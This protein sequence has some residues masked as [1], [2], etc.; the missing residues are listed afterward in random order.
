MSAL[1]E[2]AA[3]RLCAAGEGL[4]GVS[5]PLT[6][7]TVPALRDDGSRALVRGARVTMDLADV[8]RA[9]SAGLALLVDP[10]GLLVVDKDLG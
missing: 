6:F 5:G 9:D 3:A 4:V 10:V 2:G 8:G 7:D 1:G